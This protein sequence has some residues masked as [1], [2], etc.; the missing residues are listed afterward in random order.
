MTTFQIISLLI[1][2]AML[3]VAILNL[4]IKK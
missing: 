1:S 2:F 3:V 4:W